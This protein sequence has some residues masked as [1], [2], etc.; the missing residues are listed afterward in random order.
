MAGRAAITVVG[1][2]VM[3]APVG[4]EEDEEDEEDDE[5]EEVDELVPLLED[6]DVDRAGCTVT[7]GGGDS[8]ASI[9][10]VPA[11][12]KAGKGKVEVPSTAGMRA[13]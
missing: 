11:F 7:C 9:P 12:V 10:P 3:V 13:E 1:E 6:T 4:G 5:D 8:D 2:T